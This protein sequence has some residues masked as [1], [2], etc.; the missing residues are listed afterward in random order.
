MVGYHI[1][2]PDMTAGELNAFLQEHLPTPEE[3]YR[4]VLRR[5]TV[6]DDERA[7]LKSLCESYR[8]ISSRDRTP[9]VIET[10][11]GPDFIQLASGFDFYL[12]EMVRRF[13]HDRIKSALAMARYRFWA[14]VI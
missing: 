14:D 13:V 3:I 4:K 10:D 7:S 5:N 6:W 9:K 12:M 11:R 8:D 1:T 2:V